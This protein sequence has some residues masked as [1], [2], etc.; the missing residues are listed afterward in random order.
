MCILKTCHIH[1]NIEDEKRHLHEINE[2]LA[3]EEKKN[4]SNYYYK[5]QQQ[6]Q[7]KTVPNSHYIKGSHALAKSYVVGQRV[8][9]AWN[10]KDSLN[11]WYWGHITAKYM[12][13]QHPNPNSRHRNASSSTSRHGRPTTTISTK[14]TTKRELYTVT[15]DDGDKKE[16]MEREVS[17]CGSV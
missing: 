9:A 7:Q 3:E 13:H 11:G 2:I 6:Q 1:R 12:S 5:K 10:E 17:E 14:N 15:F 8:Y 4:Q 16:R